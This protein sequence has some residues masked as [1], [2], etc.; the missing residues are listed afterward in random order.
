MTAESSTTRTR[1]FLFI[2]ASSGSE[3]FRGSGLDWSAALELA[4][5]N[6]AIDRRGEPLDADLSGRRTVEQLAGEAVAEILGGYEKAFRLQ[7]VA[8]ELSVARAH[9]ERHVEHLAAADHLELEVGPLASQV[10]DVVD[11]S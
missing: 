3:Q 2:V 11:E 7:I 5:E 6:R 1:I 8:N 10:H 4:L 9:V